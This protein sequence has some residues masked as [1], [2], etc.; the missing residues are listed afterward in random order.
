M[1]GRKLK[2]CFH[3]AT[4]GGASGAAGFAYIGNIMVS[5]IGD[6]FNVSLVP[7]MIIA[8]GAVLTAY[9]FIELGR[10]MANREYLPADS[11][12]EEIYSLRRHPKS[13]LS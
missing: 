10:W 11:D 9:G 4:A 6:A 7:F 3:C 8:A 1:I 2:N 5:G 12:E 13:Q